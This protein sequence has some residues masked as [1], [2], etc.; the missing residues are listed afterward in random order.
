MPT[1][2]AFDADD[3]IVKEMEEIVKEIEQLRDGFQK[4]AH[5]VGYVKGMLDMHTRTPDAHHP[6][7][8][9]E[10]TMTMKKNK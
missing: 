9:S 7:T 4:I 5:E 1:E 3:Q 6:A 8:I 10:G 2:D